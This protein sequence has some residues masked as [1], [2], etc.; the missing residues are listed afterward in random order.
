[1]VHTALLALVRIKNNSHIIISHR[2]RRRYCRPTG[3]IFDENGYKSSVRSRRQNIFDDSFIFIII[4][5][6]AELSLT[7]PLYRLSR[8]LLSTIKLRN[9]GALKIPRD[10]ASLS[11]S[12]SPTIKYR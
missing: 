7:V 6:T 8:R 2:G 3:A 11:R 4:L 10:S 5:L 12:L 9:L 1:V